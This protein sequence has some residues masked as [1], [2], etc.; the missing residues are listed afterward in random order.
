MNL[1]LFGG[2]FDP[3]HR[4]HV[5][6]VRCA[7]EVA[8]LHRVLYLPTAQ[9]P[10]KEERDP[11][12]AWTRHA[13]AELALLDDEA[14][15]VCA[16]ELTPNRPAY[17]VETLEHFRRQHPDDVLHLLLGSD[18]LAHLTSWRRWRD[19][20]PLARLVVLARPGWD[21][22]EVRESL[23]DELHG[24]LFEGAP[25]GAP[26]P[27]VVVE[28]AVDVSATEIRRRLAAGE[29]PPA[30]WLHERVIDYIQ[31]YDLYR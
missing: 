14:L 9:P 5:E 31:K 8:E 6:P 24:L 15:H 16:Y 22:R 26:A 28:C 27:P 3:I 11:A 4:G 12:P 21:P 23:S 17:T 29:E 7:R 19:L 30:G 1:G 18:S 10:H 25:G 13:M 20:V 2:T